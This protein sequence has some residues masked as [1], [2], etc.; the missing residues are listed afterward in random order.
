M[1][2]QQQLKSYF[3]K[4]TVSDF[5]SDTVFLVQHIDRKV[6]IPCKCDPQ[7]IGDLQISCNGLDFCEFDYHYQYNRPQSD[8]PY[9]S[10][11]KG[12]HIEED[13][14]PEEIQK[15]IESIYG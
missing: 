9:E 10:E 15:K 7:Q 2:K 6:K 12:S 11:K 14:A 8:Q 3:K 13:Y 5:S 1:K 4:L